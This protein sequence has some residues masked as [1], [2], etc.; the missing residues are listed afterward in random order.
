M[1]QHILWNLLQFFEPE[2]FYANKIHKCKYG[3]YCNRLNT[4]EMPAGNNIN[5]QSSITKIY[6]M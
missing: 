1:L 2:I 5:F 4:V 6:R 3:D